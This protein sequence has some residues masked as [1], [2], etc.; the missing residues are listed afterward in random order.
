MKSTSPSL[1]LALLLVL[2]TYVP[3]Q[4]QDHLHEAPSHD[5]EHHLSGG[6]K[7]DHIPFIANQGQ[8]N[9]KVHYQAILNAGAIFLENDRITYSIISRSDLNAAH[10]AQRL[11]DY[12][13]NLEQ[14]MVRGHAYA[15][16]FEGAQ[17]NIGL[18]AEGKHSD[19]YN[20]FKGQDQ[21]RW[22]TQVPAF[23]EVQYHGIYPGIDL[24]AHCAENHFK[25]DFV[26]APG[27]NVAAIR[28]KYTGGVTL[29]L[30]EDNLVIATT[31]GDMIE[32]RPVA[33]QVIDGRQV[34]VPVA[35]Q[36]L[37]EHTVGFLLPKGYDA[38]REL[39][40]DP[41][42]I[43][44]TYS[45]SVGADTYGHTATFDDQGNIYGAGT[46]FGIGYPITTGAFQTTFA[47]NTDFGISKLNPDGSA[48]LYST[49][50]GGTNDDRPHSMIVNSMDQLCVLG[51]SNSSDFPVATNG[52]DPTWNSN[53]DITV[54]VF[55]PNGTALVG[56]S[57]LGGTG[58]DGKNVVT[59]FYGDAYRGEINVD[60]QDRI[61]IASFTESA[62]F[63]VGTSAYQNQLV[64]N[65]DGIIARFSPDL[66]Q[67]DW[68]TYFGDTLDDAVF[69]V[70]I[71]LD[72]TLYVCGAATAGMPATTGA[73]QTTNQ[74]GI[75]G[76][77]AHL[78]ADGQNLLELSYFGTPGTD[79][80]FFLELD[81]F[82]DVYLFGRS[83]DTLNPTTGAYVGPSNGSF[84]TKMTPDLSSVTLL[85]TFGLVVPTAFLV[86]NCNNIYIAGHGANGNSF[87]L[88]VTQGAFQS[89]TG[90]FYVMVLEPNATNIQYGS[91]YS[92][93]GAH[94]DGGT[95][96]FDKRGVI[97]EAVCASNGA[98]TTSNAVGQVSQSTWDLYLFKIDLEFSGTIANAFAA[99]SI[100][101]CVP[102]NVQFSSQG[103]VG[104][105][106][107]WDFDDNGTTDTSANPTHVF[108]DTGWYQVQL[109]TID[110]LSCNFSDTAVVSVYVGD[111]LELNL[112]P[113]TTVCDS[114]FVFD[115]GALPATNYSWSSNG[116]QSQ[117]V[118]NNGG[119]FILTLDRGNCSISDTMNVSLVPSLSTDLGPDTF[120]C[121]TSF[122]LSAN[123]TGVSYLWSDSSSA[124]DLT[125]TTT[126]TY[127][128]QSDAGVCQSRDSVF[129]DFAA[130]V[131]AL[132]GDT[133]VC[134]DTLLLDA[135]AGQTFL[136]NGGDTT[137]T[138][139]VDSSGIYT[140]QVSNG[141]CAGQ[142]SIQVTIQDEIVINLAAD[143]S[144]CEDSLVLN[145]GNP[146]SQFVWSNSAL[147]QQTTINNSGIY[148][149][150]VTSGA[151]QSA[152]TIQVSFDAP[153][154]GIAD[155]VICD[156][157]Q[158]VLD[159]GNPGATYLW[160]TGATTRTLQVSQ[161]GEYSV[162]ITQQQCSGTDTAIV[163]FG[164]T[165]EIDLGP[166]QY[167]CFGAFLELEAPGNANLSYVWSGGNTTQTTRI[168]A[169][170]RYWVEANNG[171]CTNTDTIQ[172]TEVK[173]ELILLAPNVFTPNGDGLNDCFQLEIAG[174]VSTY[175]LVIF[176]RW[177][178]RVF[179]NNFSGV[180]WDGRT[181]QG[182]AVSE[183]VYFWIATVESECNPGQKEKVTGSL[184]LMR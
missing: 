172:V 36:L 98:P 90:G 110:S 103:S 123:L 137:Q 128:L 178:N 8:W 121:D 16:T 118:T 152:D 30:Q 20:F 149:V 63:P 117:L 131:P 52:Y 89:N 141:L 113:D 94:V 176:N 163:A 67:L 75:D 101:G 86:D 82:G 111:T 153:Q 115:P 49:L 92:N 155:Q 165:P 182:Q 42:L 107:L 65:Q 95:S 70:K 51:S 114:M 133:T 56:G 39:I 6:P 169:G 61:Y 32:Q 50:I 46:S 15:M 84:I 31:V 53:Y 174:E 54:T 140:V 135:G 102:F 13:Q 143:T 93:N 144:V 73:Y 124:P 25:Y 177:G 60:F 130:V 179:G 108:N 159:A 80:A 64:G 79:V 35:F 183:G 14:L 66:S 150:T 40:I 88:E 119:T 48:R 19:Y 7:P 129:V 62:D 126:G 91:F 99:P 74:G 105:S 18:A 33:Y 5:H 23:S 41:V 145:A 22:A 55:N 11:P 125:V 4:G 181:N 166:D 24:H 146:G 100:S 44:A 12:H 151:C 156:E 77:V 76:Y 136:W 106:R 28:L 68:A 139:L 116:N 168:T 175:E 127:W 109:V 3:G 167:L 97:Y 38:S 37:D 132:G 157:L 170:G 9:A 122:L 2:F 10:D 17:S 148:A 154:L 161:P 34:E 142:D 147:T 69:N 158:T 180:C 72:Q 162:L 134:E 81:K 160:S 21:S 27:A 164:E 120:T 1:F 58:D 59:Q 87:N 47:G 85:S 71:A 78:S 26:V 104:V 138:L 43:T 83:N 57:F 171:L 96:R 173:D 29:S 112:P 45:G 184:T